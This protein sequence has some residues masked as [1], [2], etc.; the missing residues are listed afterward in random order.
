[1]HPPP[2]EEGEVQKEEKVWVRVRLR[3]TR[4]RGAQD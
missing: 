3:G 1:M 4:V 2:P